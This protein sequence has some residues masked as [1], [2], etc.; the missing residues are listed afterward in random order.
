MKALLIAAVVIIL[1]VI[2]SHAAH[3]SNIT[4]PSAP[5]TT[6]GSYAVGQNGV[7]TLVDAGVSTDMI[8]QDVAAQFPQLSSD[9]IDSYVAKW[10]AAC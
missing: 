1:I 3:S 9:T 6:S 5:P 7:C 2:G 4:T 8:D 10:A